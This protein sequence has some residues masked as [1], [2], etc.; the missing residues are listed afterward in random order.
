MIRLRTALFVV[1]AGC[2]AWY[3]ALAGFVCAC[4]EM[5]GQAEVYP[6]HR[7]PEAPEPTVYM[8]VGALAGAILGAITLLIV[9]MLERGRERRGTDQA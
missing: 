4:A 3:G 1:G 8:A 7:I 9:A 5:L 6:P 2:G